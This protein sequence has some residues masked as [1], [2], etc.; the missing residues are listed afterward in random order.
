MMQFDIHS[1]PS[2]EDEIHTM[3]EGGTMR[4]PTNER[5]WSM[6]NSASIPT[7]SAP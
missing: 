4:F 6:G 1:K 7:K 5:F 3:R 2:T